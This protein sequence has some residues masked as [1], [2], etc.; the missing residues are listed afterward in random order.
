MLRKG[1]GSKLLDGYSDRQISKEGRRAQR[2]N[3]YNNNNKDERNSQS[4][5]NGNNSFS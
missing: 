5:N 1:F 2:Q 3:C 4:V